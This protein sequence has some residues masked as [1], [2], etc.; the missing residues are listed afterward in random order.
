VLTYTI[1]S[2]RLT[3]VRLQDEELVVETIEDVI[4][5]FG[6]D[7]AQKTT[8]STMRGSTHYHLKNGSGKGVLEITYWPKK[9]WLTVDIHDN[10]RAP[11]NEQ[12]IGPLARALAERFAGEVLTPAEQSKTGSDAQEHG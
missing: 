11:W 6:L 7:T 2:S 12:L 8:L 10:R 1:V 5:D 4:R 3:P 9:A